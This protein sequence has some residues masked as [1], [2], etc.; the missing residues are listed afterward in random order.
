MLLSVKLPQL[1]RLFHCSPGI[2]VTEGGGAF[3][4][5]QQLRNSADFLDPLIV[6][7][8]QIL[9]HTAIA[10]GSQA[11]GVDRGGQGKTRARS[12]VRVG[13]DRRSLQGKATVP[14]RGRGWRLTRLIACDPARSRGVG[15]RSRGWKIPLC[16]LPGDPQDP[17]PAVDEFVLQ[18]HDVAHVI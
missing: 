3:L 1:G 17:W 7:D 2:V 10:T 11:L 8:L 16:P 14:V 15:S 5:R 13:G 4:G 18:M 12:D 9:D 6:Q